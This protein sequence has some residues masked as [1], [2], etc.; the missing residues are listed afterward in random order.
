AMLTGDH[1]ATATAVARGAGID[2]VR[3]ELLPDDKR[4]AVA[5]LSRR[6]PVLMVGDGIND[7]PAL[8][9]A[10]VGMAMGALGSGVAV[11][12]ADIAI[13]SDDLTHLPGL[14]A[15]A[16]RTRGIMVQNL[17]LSGLIIA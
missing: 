9:T 12:S 15:H 13:M 1:Q 16:R 14:V 5:E 8:A 11:E 4:A 7:A 2:D 10:D 6:A 3:A 17:L